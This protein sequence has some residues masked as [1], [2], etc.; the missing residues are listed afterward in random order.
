MVKFPI[1]ITSKG[2]PDNEVSKD[3]KKEG[4]DYIIVVNKDEVNE[5]KKLH[6]NVMVGGKGHYGA[7]N[8]IFDKHKDGDF[9]WILQ[10][11][12][13]KFKNGFKKSLS[14]LE[15][16]ANKDTGMLGY[17]N[18][19]FHFKHPKYT[20]NSFVINVILHQ[21]KD[22]I[23]ADPNTLY[24]LETDL[25]TNYIKNG[26]HSIRDNDIHLTSKKTFTDL[27]G[28]GNTS[29]YLNP[30]NKKSNFIKDLNEKQKK[31]IVMDNL[32]KQS[33][34]ARDNMI[35]KYKLPLDYFKLGTD[36]RYGIVEGYFKKVDK[37]F[38]KN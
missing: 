26:L 8:S 17:K 6:K 38:N 10:D 33:K 35:K 12:A 3:L 20:K 31:K 34:K 2:R 1:Y 9:V 18:L 23:R 37:L 4:L 14:S 28:G 25:L 29:L 16:Q 15:S 27:D 21:V 19:N 5:Y 24:F 7:Y 30:D 11:N 13:G 22:N 32:I 36:G